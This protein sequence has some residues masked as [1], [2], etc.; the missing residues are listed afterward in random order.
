MFQSSVFHVELLFFCAQ[1]QPEAEVCQE[2]HSKKK[3]TGSMS[4]RSP[5]SYVTDAFK[6]GSKAATCGTILLNT[7]E[8]QDY[9]ASLCAANGARYNVHCPQEFPDLRQNP[10]N[11]S[12]LAA[13]VDSPSKAPR[14]G[15]IRPQKKRGE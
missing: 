1:D 9:P 13:T 3:P 6:T 7:S 14:R 2:Q 10:S 12:D 11:A 5:T 15:R 4:S 8:F